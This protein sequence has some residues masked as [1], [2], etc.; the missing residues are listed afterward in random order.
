M[1]DAPGKIAIAQLAVFAAAFPLALY[2]LFRHGKHG[3]LGWFFISVFCVIR[4]IG[5]AM[6]V[7]DESR[8][9]PLGEGGL[10]ISS[11]AVAPLIIAIGGIAHESYF[12][13][14]LGEFSDCPLLTMILDT[15]PLK[16]TGVSFLAS[17]P[18]SSCTSDVWEQ[19]Q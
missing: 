7:H 6:V 12:I 18:I 2:C 10:I 3:L 11:V 1:F 9:K 5:S 15:S 13:L 19:L 4:V 16:H 14:F 8:Q 17:F